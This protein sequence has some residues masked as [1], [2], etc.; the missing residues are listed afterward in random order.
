[1]GTV[2]WEAIYGGFGRVHF[3][4]D[5]EF[6]LE[7]KALTADRIWVTACATVIVLH[8]T[9]PTVFHMPL[10]DFVRRLSVQPMRLDASRCEACF[11]A[12]GVPV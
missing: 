4:Y 8:P 11:T 3:A 9:S 10:E 5:S 1:M 12:L 6:G 7:R 2:V